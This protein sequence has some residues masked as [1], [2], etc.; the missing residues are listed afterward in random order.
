MASVR[1]LRSVVHQIADD[2]RKG[3]RRHVRARLRLLKNFRQHTRYPGAPRGAIVNIVRL[4]IA[5]ESRNDAAAAI[6]KKRF[7]AVLCVPTDHVGEVPDCALFEL[8]LSFVE[9]QPDALYVTCG[10]NNRGQRM[11]YLK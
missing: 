7:L 3:L 10:T 5:Q 1:G 8:H 9:L 4:T 6:R 2:A 11:F